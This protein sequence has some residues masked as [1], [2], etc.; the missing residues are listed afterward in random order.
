LVALPMWQPNHHRCMPPPAWRYRQLRQRPSAATTTD[1][2]DR[3]YRHSCRGTPSCPGRW[4][5]ASAIDARPERIAWRR[6][7]PAR[8]R[9]RLYSCGYNPGLRG[10]GTP[11]AD[12]HNRGRPGPTD[13]LRHTRIQGWDRGK[14]CSSLL[15]C[16]T[17]VR[18][19]MRAALPLILVSACP[20]RDNPGVKPCVC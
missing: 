8:R 10:L 13:P 7:N 2:G 12:T 14:N 6:V 20:Y 5:R 4:R 18:P 17:A 19:A 16:V 1:R 11:S 3:Y 9:T 15:R